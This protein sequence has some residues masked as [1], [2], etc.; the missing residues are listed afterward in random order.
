MMPLI[1]GLYHMAQENWSIALGLL[2]GE[3]YLEYKRCCCVM[4]EETERLTGQLTGD[5]LT[6][7]KRY[8]ADLEQVQYTEHRLSFARGLSMGLS[9]A[10][11]A[12]GE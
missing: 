3:E 8:L 4:E 10:A 5:A 12:K 9:L 11:L 6:T 7:W 2:D 1:E